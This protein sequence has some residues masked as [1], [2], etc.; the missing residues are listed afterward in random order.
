[1]KR[2]GEGEMQAVHAQRLFHLTSSQAHARL[3]GGF[4]TK[5]RTSS[6]ILALIWRGSI[7]NLRFV[8][9][10]CPKRLSGYSAV[11]T[12]RRSGR[13]PGRGKVMFQ[14]FAFADANSTPT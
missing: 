10:L 9:E 4:V 2:D 6:G 3:S 13:S 11:F 14:N 8:A 1:M 7:V 5:G 12:M